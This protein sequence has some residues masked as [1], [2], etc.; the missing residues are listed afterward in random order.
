MMMSSVSSDLS[1]TFEERPRVDDRV[2]ALVDGGHHFCTIDRAVVINSVVP[3]IRQHRAT[4]AALIKQL[5]LP[6]LDAPQGTRSTRA[7]AAA[8]SR[9]QKRS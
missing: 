5:A 1:R 4:L 9:S 3:E 7:R 6:D 8:I 2:V